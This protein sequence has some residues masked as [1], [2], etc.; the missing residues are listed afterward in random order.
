MGH[1]HT[2]LT[3]RPNVSFDS[4]MTAGLSDEACVGDEQA[5]TTPNGNTLWATAVQTVPNPVDEFWMLPVWQFLHFVDFIC[6]LR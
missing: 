1:C 5:F 4:V 2:R 3:D 6:R